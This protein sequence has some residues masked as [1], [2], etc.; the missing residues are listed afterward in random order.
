MGAQTTREEE[1]GTP[2]SNDEEVLKQ[3]YQV[4]KERQ[5][6]KPGPRLYPFPKNDHVVTKMGKMP[7]S[8]CRLCGS[9]KHWNREC[10]NYVLYDTGSKRQGKMSE[11]RRVSEEEEMYDN[12]FTVFATSSIDFSRFEAASSATKVEGNKTASGTEGIGSIYQDSQKSE[13]GRMGAE[14][15]RAP[16]EREIDKGPADGAATGTESEIQ[17]KRDS[18]E[19]RRSQKLSS[20]EEVP[21]EEPERDAPVN[22][23][24]LLEEVT[25]REEEVVASE[26]VFTPTVDW[27]SARRAREA[28]KVSAVAEQ[29]WLNDGKM[30]GGADD[31]SPDEDDSDWDGESDEEDPESVEALREALNAERAEG[32]AFKESQGQIVAPP[33]RDLTP[34]RLFKKR[35]SMESGSTTLV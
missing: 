34:I 10:P 16:S 23:G 30:F 13:L 8:P 7:P 6:A 20:V 5:A 25:P 17:D 19:Q 4:L 9:D 11:H 22:P 15:N 32:E 24:V 21:E 28:A 26:D 33:P 29:F 2:T 27:K 31:E 12:A 35:I 14:A 18:T 3:V 1:D